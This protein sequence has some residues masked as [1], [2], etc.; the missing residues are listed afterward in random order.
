MPRRLATSSSAYLRQHADN[1]VDWWE[2]STEAFEEAAR[3]NVPVF[4]SIGYAACHWCHVMA[5]ESFE[6]PVIADFLNQHFVSIKV[7]REERPDVDAVYMTATQ[8][9]SGHGG[10]PMSVF[11]FPDGRP[12]MAGT[13]FPPVDRHGTPGFPRLLHALHDAWNSQQTLLV[14]QAEEIERAIA[15]EITVI[16]RVAPY[17][18][19]LQETAEQLVADLLRRVERH[20]GFSPAPKFPRPAY[21]EGLLTSLEVPGVREAIA[22]TLNSMSRRGMYDHMGGGFARYSVDAEWHVPHFEQ[23]L[24]DQALL[25]TTYLR[26]HRAF[27]G[28]TEWAD[29]AQRTLDAMIDRFWLGGGFASSLDADAEGHE[30]RHVTWTLEEVR[31]TLVS[32]GLGNL[33][34]PIVTRYSFDRS[35]AFEGRLIPTLLDGEPFTP[36]PHLAQAVD[37]LLRARSERIQPG[38]DEKI[39]LEWNA[40]AIVALVESGDPRH[41]QFAASTWDAVSVTHYDGRQWWRTD[42]RTASATS[43][44]LAW[45]MRAG[46]ALYQATGSDHYLQQVL[47]L[48]N[49]LLSHY[50]DGP[51]PQSPLVVD[52]RGFFTTRDNVA[53]LA[54]RP[55]EIFDGS[56]PS[57]HSVATHAFAELSAVT[58]DPLHRAVTDHLVRL[59]GSVARDHP[60]AVPDFINALGLAL[61]PRQIVIPGQ[62]PEWAG[63][64]RN[65]F[66]PHSVTVRGSGS[67]P[68]LDGRTEGAVYLCEGGTCQLPARTLDELVAQL[69]AFGTVVKP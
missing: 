21:I 64:L 31:E 19:S 8:A 42:A 38:R 10:W 62:Q 18:P 20:G 33:Y 48:S 63:V 6:D 17:V 1:P 22:V 3:R 45:M 69:A 40:M 55:K 46:L 30:G 34:L 50:W 2:W 13:Y 66:I 4:L 43:T 59:V 56:V 15:H 35:P 68:L 16:D 36:P 23:M 47:S 60:S 49:E 14:E 53:D 52:G 51:T 5:H 11:L 65:C 58:S 61:R 9:V 67:T 39:V 7:D 41:A 44:D 12:F 54:W 24:S 26:A 29:V 28:T 37:V 25:A 57:S 32:A 27:G